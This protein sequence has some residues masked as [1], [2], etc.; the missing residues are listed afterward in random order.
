MLVN[1][2][3]GD[4]GSYVMMGRVLVELL[5]FPI[6]ILNS[7]IYKRHIKTHRS[8]Q[9][10]LLVTTIAV[11]H[12][13]KVAFVPIFKFTGISWLICELPIER[14]DVKYCKTTFQLDGSFTKLKM[15]AFS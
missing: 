10:M 3:T 6:N 2:H 12:F 5:S 11:L 7:V 9:N 13:E 4:D 14:F 8:M 1:A 15:T